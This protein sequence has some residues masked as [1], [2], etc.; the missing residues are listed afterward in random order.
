MSR[1][2]WW[3]LSHHPGSE[4]LNLICWAHHVA[5]DCWDPL[6]PQQ[7]VWILQQLQGGEEL[8]GG[9][10]GGV[11]LDADH[12][13]DGGSDGLCVQTPDTAQHEVSAD[14]WPEEVWSRGQWQCG[15]QELGQ[16]TDSAPVLWHQDSPGQCQQ[17][18]SSRCVPYLL[19]QVEH[20]WQIWKY[21]PAV[22]VEV[23]Q[24]IIVPRSCCRDDS[25]TCNTSSGVIV[26]RIWTDDCYHK[27]QIMIDD[28][29]W[30]S[31]CRVLSSCRCTASSWAVSLSLLQSAWWVTMIT[32]Q[33]WD[34]TRTNK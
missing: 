34:H 18:V 12:P 28:C 29:Q 22:N 24:E 27:V 16:D 1:P 33:Y 17:S 8:A 20:A 32:R 5:G 21:N 26:D 13:G 19:S 7:F 14:V 10:P 15:D 4:C 3:P 25:E 6:P 2:V 30:L 31:C 9:V 23:G 11:H